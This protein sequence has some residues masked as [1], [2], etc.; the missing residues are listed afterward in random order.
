M[1]R[2]KCDQGRP[3][4]GCSLSRRLRVPIS[5]ATI[6]LL[7]SSS[8]F[9]MENGATNWQNMP[10]LISSAQASGSGDK[11]ARE[12]AKK[13]EK[14]ARKQAEEQQK[15]A[16][17]QQERAREQAKRQQEEARKR[18]K[19]QQERAREQQ[20]RARE[21]QERSAKLAKRPKDG[22]RDHQSKEQKKKKKYKDKKDDD[23]HDD[24][25]DESHLPRDKEHSS[26][27]DDDLPPQTL[28]ELFQQI[29]KPKTK[30]VVTPPA[31]SKKPRRHYRPISK[32]F[33][34]PR[35]Q[36]AS[37]EVLAVGLGRKGFQKARSLGFKL[38]SKENFSSLDLS[39]TRLLPPRGLSPIQARVLLK[40]EL[41]SQTTIS[42]N[43]VYRVYHA[44][45]GTGEK[46][47]ERPAARALPRMKPKGFDHLYGQSLIKWKPKLKKCAQPVR[48]GVIDTSI[49]HSHYAFKGKRL[50][51]GNFIPEG[52][53]R[54]ENWHGT[55]VLALLSG[56]PGSGTPGLISDSDFYVANVFY[57]DKQGYPLTDSISLLKALDWMDVLDVNVIN[58]SVAGQRDALI[59]RAISRLSKKGVIF[60]AAGGNEGPA[61]APSYPAAYPQVIAVTAVN[62][63]LR[64]Y[65]YANRGKYIDLS[66]P[67]V[68]IWTAVPGQKQGF[69][70]GTSFAV[71]YVTSI[72]AALYGEASKKSKAG[73][74]KHI[75]V[76]DL[77][78]PGRDPI[79]G[80]GLIEAPSN[81]RSGPPQLAQSIP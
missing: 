51:I 46:S 79:F 50:S 23:D 59:E 68:D 71:P 44:A 27:N 62:K 37:R 24:K 78:A 64:G 75:K 7:L 1:K 4:R 9:T 72:V 52:K 66:A 70:S 41:R 58:M 48:I 49:D 39:V 74:L 63:K 25:D 55:G 31:I 28:V 10:W 3:H 14:R 36:F 45:T 80:L 47:K 54:A 35:A 65:R 43:K 8:P 69:Q 57:A 56:D 13:A 29:A 15:R 60:V 30:A 32:E 81:C 61:A 26:Y 42:L 2:I 33:L 67:G 19:E 21:Q 18:A 17:K 5:I 38:R 40:R 16:R 76:R 77:G 53:P 22:S 73:V 6:L 34:S 12:E 11:K 20:Q